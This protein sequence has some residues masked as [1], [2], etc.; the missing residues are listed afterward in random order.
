MSGRIVG[1]EWDEEDR[2]AVEFLATQ[3]LKTIDAFLNTEGGDLLNGVADDGL[4]VG[5]ETDQLN[6]DHKFMRH[7][8]QAVRNGLGD[9]AAPPLDRTSRT[10]SNLNSTSVSTETGEGQTCESLLIRLRPGS[11]LRTVDHLAGFVGPQ[12]GES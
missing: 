4:I 10:G 7:L 2:I 9:R 8:A 12:S 6:N 1:G 3:A 5:I 11:K